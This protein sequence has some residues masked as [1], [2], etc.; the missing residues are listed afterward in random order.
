MRDQQGRKFQSVPLDTPDSVNFLLSFLAILVHQ[1]GG[2]IEI[3]K[4]SEYAGHNVQ[5]G[6]EI[7]EAG[8]RVIIFGTANEPDQTPQ[9]FPPEDDKPRSESLWKSGKSRKH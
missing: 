5:L 4:L 9:V 6:Y 1:S 8:D 7:D 3:D 2:R